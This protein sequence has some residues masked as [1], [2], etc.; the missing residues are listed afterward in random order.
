VCLRLEK[1]Q[2]RRRGVERSGKERR[3]VVNGS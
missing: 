2:V 3:G 1:G